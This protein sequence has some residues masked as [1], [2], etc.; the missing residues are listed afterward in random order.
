MVLKLYGNALA[1]CTQRVLVTLKEKNVPY[2]LI[3]VDLT[4][5]EHKTPAYLEKQPF[6]QIPYIDDDGFI[7]FESVAICKYIA[8]KYRSSG[9]SLIPVPDDF[10]AY[11]RFEQ[12]TSIEA[13]EFYPFIGEIILQYFGKLFRGVEPDEKVIAENI[14]KLT[15]KLNGYE[16]ILKKQKYIAGDSITVADLAHLPNGAVIGV[17]GLKLLEDAERWPNVARWWKDISSRPNWTE[18]FSAGGLEALIEQKA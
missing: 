5:G 8:T 18:V 13:A 15:R 3:K 17:F 9:T 4:K 10:E 12:A 1:G 2:E 16:T 14:E 7:L 6:G 11:G